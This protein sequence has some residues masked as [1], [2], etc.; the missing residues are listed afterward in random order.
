MKDKFYAYIQNL[1]DTIVAG[2]EAVDGQAK[3]REDFGNAQK[4][5]E[6]EPA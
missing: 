1:Q 4:A 5:E 2:L 3:F 6:E